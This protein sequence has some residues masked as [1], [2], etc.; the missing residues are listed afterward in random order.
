MR[1][2][3]ES[4][5]DER[6]FGKD[7]MNLAEFPIT[8]LADRKD[9]NLI[10]REVPVRDESTGLMILRKV[11][12]TGSDLY[13][14]PSSQDNLILL[15]LIYLTKRA[16]N[17]RE[18]RVGFSRS[19]V[20]KVLGWADSGQSYARIELSLKRWANV[21]VLYENAWWDKPRQTYSSKGFGIIDDFEINDGSAS[22]QATLLR[23][24]IA[25]NEIFFQS[26]EAGFVR[27]I[28]LKLLLRLRHP[29]SQQMYR[30]LGKHF[31]HSPSLTLDLRTFACE[32]VGLDRGYKDN[33]K[34]KEKLQPAIDELEQIGFLEP[35]EKERRY[36][37]VGP[38]QWTI[39]LRRRADLEL[40]E[41]TLDAGSPLAGPEPT[42]QEK[43]LV[44]RGVTATVAAELALNHPA[45]SIQGKI[46][47]F[48]WLVERRDKRVSK[49]PAGYLA[50]SIRKDYTAPRGFES[51]AQRRE[52]LAA[53]DEQRRKVE[54]ARRRVAEE[55]RAK[56][57]AD[58]ARIQGHWAK[59][60]EAERTR[61]QDDALASP[62]L[63]FLVKRYRAQ[64]DPELAARTLKMIL[65]GHI[66]GLLDDRPRR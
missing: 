36:A 35:M 26:L 2:T 54:D 64:A 25:W 17:F 30:F 8:L 63:A 62:G 19:E 51:E 31:Y 42:E 39:T 41:E 15:G 27:T 24:N 11:T 4:V 65:D 50:E 5:P 52:R 20:I 56:E 16:N 28:D 58:Q 49:N 57:Q 10:I 45:D 29:S 33:G 9:V 66:L 21:F 32:H 7:E 40:V 12:V 48:D 3:P 34:L 47:V 46:E 13:G 14:L 22:R 1:A 61:L 59:L 53:L 60:S 38:K 44:A 55:Q 6:L 23:S 43:G 18:R 37:K